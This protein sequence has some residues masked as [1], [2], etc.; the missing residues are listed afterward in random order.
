MVALGHSGFGGDCGG[1]WGGCVGFG[2]GYEK[3]HNI[4]L[5]LGFEEERG[6]IGLGLGFK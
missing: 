1:A 6:Y 3:E 5:G 4:G 2:L